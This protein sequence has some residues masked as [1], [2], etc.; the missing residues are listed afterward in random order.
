[1]TINNICILWS[2]Y[3]SRTAICHIIIANKLGN[4][5]HHSFFFAFHFA[6]SDGLCGNGFSSFVQPHNS[7]T[8]NNWVN[9]CY[10]LFWIHT[11]HLYNCEVSWTVSL[12][13]LQSFFRLLII[14][15]WC[16][17]SS[18]ADAIR[19]WAVLNA[20][21]KK[22]QQHQRVSATCRSRLWIWNLQTF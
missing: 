10:I 17:D 6:L 4:I 13:C 18:T 16:L 21:R 14:I 20:C 22:R 7:R 19:W 8:V 3:E 9:S 5:L 15:W 12:A 11:A 2:N 1:M